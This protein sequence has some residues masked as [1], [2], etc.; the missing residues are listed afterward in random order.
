MT[1]ARTRPVVG[2]KDIDSGKIDWH[3]S[4]DPGGAYQTLCGLSLN[5]DQFELQLPVGSQKI[6]F[7][8]CARVFSG[9]RNL[10]R[11]SDFDERSTK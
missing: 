7:R 8:D 1:K 9:V 6:T 11:I 2:S 10:F 5:D 3:A 4:F